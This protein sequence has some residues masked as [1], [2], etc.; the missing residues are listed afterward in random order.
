MT[1]TFCVTVPVLCWYP[2]TLNSGVF[3]F[4]SGS[5][6]DQ[7]MP[8]LLDTLPGG[9]REPSIL[10]KD[11]VPASAVLSRIRQNEKR[12]NQESGSR[13]AFWL[14]SGVLVARSQEPP[15]GY[16]NYQGPN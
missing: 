11:A 5:S 16:G 12:K 7:T 2:L 14:T 13:F 1:W 10:S 4:K 3:C 8:I 9:D 15:G 6:D